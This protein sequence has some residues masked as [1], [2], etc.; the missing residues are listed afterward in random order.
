MKRYG[1]IG[2]PL[3][4]SF[5]KKYFAQKFEKEGIKGASYELFEIP[6]VDQMPSL[7]EN[8][9]DLKGLNVT[10]PYKQDVI[11]LLD[12]LDDQAAKIGAV[13]VIK[14]EFNGQLI[15]YNSD[16]YGFLNSL[17]SFAGNDLPQLKALVLGT[18]GASK[19]VHAALDSLGVS[20]KK[21]SR[22]AGDQVITYKD[23][24]PELIKSYRLIINTTPLGMH[25]NTDQAP[26]LPYECMDENVYLYDLVYNP[27]ETTFM[28]KGAAKGAHTIN[29]LDMLIGQAEKAWEIWNS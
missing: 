10:I 23:V 5:S 13:N 1:L 3:S 20:Y 16:Y 8:F 28:K 2:Y 17:K 24:T 12:D 9:P 25:P 29:G 6:A 18:G 15:G 21:V 4:H 19:A 22:K 7:W 14:K 27:E 26:N 11:P